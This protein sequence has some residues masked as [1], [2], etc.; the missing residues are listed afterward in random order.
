MSIVR[1]VF[2]HCLRLMR[3][4][5]VELMNWWVDAR[6][7]GEDNKFVIN[8]SFI[9]KSFVTS[10]ISNGRTESSTEFDTSL[11]T[12]LTIIETGLTHK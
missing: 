2:T 8:S 3:E 7:V 5:S 12:S 6:S 11:K 9:L 10:F 1:I 4:G